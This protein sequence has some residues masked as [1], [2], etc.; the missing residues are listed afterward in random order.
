MTIMCIQ[1]HLSQCFIVL[2]GAWRVL[3]CYVWYL[4]Q[5]LQREG[6]ARDSFMSLSAFF[7]ILQDAWRLLDC[8]VWLRSIPFDPFTK[9]CGVKVS[10]MTILCVQSCSYWCFMH[11]MHSI[12]G[13]K[14]YIAYHCIAKLHYIA[15]ICTHNARGEY[16]L[17]IS[18]IC[19]RHAKTWSVKNPVERTQGLS[20]QRGRW[21]IKGIPVRE[22]SRWFILIRHVQRGPKTGLRCK[23][24]RLYP[25]SFRDWCVMMCQCQAATCSFRAFQCVLCVRSEKLHM[26]TLPLDHKAKGLCV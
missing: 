20:P 17:T 15:L 11:S 18:Y 22:C 7:W 3:E 4:H 9:S 19:V 25:A 5:L 23:S 2:R 1:W 10:L 26:T 21:G 6:I 14:H 13:R 12:A 8:Y 16:H 24:W